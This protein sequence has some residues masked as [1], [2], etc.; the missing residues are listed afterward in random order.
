MTNFEKKPTHATHPAG[1]TDAPENFLAT[2]RL[3]VKFSLTQSR[4]VAKA[5]LSVAL[6]ALVLSFASVAPLAQSPTSKP[7]A[8]TQTQQTASSSR[9]QSIAFESKLI[10][11]TL[12]YMVLLP[13][14]YDA[15]SARATRYPVLYL[16]HGLGGQPT[17]WF[18][19][20]MNLVAAAEGYPVILVAVTG[21][22]GW[23][24]D[25]ASVATDKYETSLLEELIPDVQKRFRTIEAREGRGIAGLSMGGY[26]ALKFGIKHPETFAFAGS[27]SGALNI[28]SAGEAELAAVPLILTSVMKTFGPLD[29]PT[30]ASNDIFKLVRGLPAARLNAL[31]FLYLDCGTEDLF[32]LLG[33]NR[34]LS[35]L[36][37]ERKIPHEYRE[38]PG[39]HNMAYWGHQSPE[40]L[41]VAT[42]NLKL[43]T[44][45]TTT[46]SH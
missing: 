38:R 29:S 14:D 44:M 9:V 46:L 31:P 2:L 26:G 43:P 6:L 17:N 10:G 8:T 40:L 25:S 32:Q 39:D 4:K 18:A 24:T 30:R 20:R 41:R 1:S 37:I 22:A 34:S 5:S 16:L 12:P 27:M 19:P 7:A 23:Y 42:E 3:C 13:K 28:A 21:N 36:L 33:A 15:A 11:K 35:D 45:T